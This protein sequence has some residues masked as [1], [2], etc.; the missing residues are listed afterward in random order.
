MP[1]FLLCST[2]AATV[3]FV[4]ENPFLRNITPCI[5]PSST[6]LMPIPLHRHLVKTRRWGWSVDVAASMM[7]IS[8]PPTSGKAEEATNREIQHGKFWDILRHHIIKLWN[9]NIIWK[10]DSET[11]PSYW[12]N[13]GPLQTVPTFARP[14]GASASFTSLRGGG[15]FSAYDNLHNHRNS[16]L[17]FFVMQLVTLRMYL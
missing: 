10:V 11:T 12:L 17:W 15:H 13:Q 7:K 4:H 5:T 6:W 3:I 1:F 14:R 16:A 9:D 2:P 8:P